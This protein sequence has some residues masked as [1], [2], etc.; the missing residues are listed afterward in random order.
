[1]YG[2][3]PGGWP[4]SC[5][6]TNVLEVQS[7]FIFEMAPHNV[8]AMNLLKMPKWGVRMAVRQMFFGDILGM[9]IS[10]CRSMVRIYKDGGFEYA[11]DD[12]PDASMPSVVTWNFPFTFYVTF[13]ISNSA[14]RRASNCPVACARLSMA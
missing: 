12:V 1:M 8:P 11:P 10:M 3:K 6:S 5:T 13:E 2:A 14:W 7:A 4:S 9:F